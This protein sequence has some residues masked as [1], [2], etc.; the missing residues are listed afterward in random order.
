MIGF[1]P[2][3]APF[4]VEQENYWRAIVWLRNFA[5]WHQPD[6]PIDLLPDRDDAIKSE[7]SGMLLE[8][9]KQLNGRRNVWLT[10]H[11]LRVRVWSGSAILDASIDRTASRLADKLESIKEARNIGLVVDRHE[12]GGVVRFR[13]Y[14]NSEST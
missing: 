10:S 9:Y 4:H 11:E 3:P 8:I 7:L 5:D 13:L 1:D 12:D 6:T 2:A 14:K